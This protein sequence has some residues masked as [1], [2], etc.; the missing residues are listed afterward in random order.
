MKKRDKVKQAKLQK[1]KMKR[2]AYEK[3]RKLRP[4]AAAPKELLS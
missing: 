1:I 4:K 2:A 3:S